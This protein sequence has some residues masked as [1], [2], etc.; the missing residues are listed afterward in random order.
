LET[1][2]KNGIIASFIFLSMGMIGDVA[3]PGFIIWPGRR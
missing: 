1:G 2:I 3:A